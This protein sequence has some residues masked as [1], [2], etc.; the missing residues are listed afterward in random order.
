MKRNTELSYL[1]PVLLVISLGFLLLSA[2]HADRSLT[3]SLITKDGPL[4]ISAYSL[5]VFPNSLYPAFFVLS[6]ILLHVYMRVRLPESDPF[7]LPTVAFLA[8]IGL[9]MMLRLSP[10]LAITR[11][12]VIL[13]VIARN[14]DAQIRNN[15]SALLQLGQKQLFFSIAGILALIISINVFNDRVFARISSKKY[16]WV[17]LSV[18]LI[19]ATL[20][21]GTKING[22]RLWLF[23]FQTVEMVK[24]LMV[25]FMASYIYEKG[26][27]ISIAGTTG[28]RSWP[29]YGGPFLVMCFFAL[30][31][32]FI[33]G[34]LGPTIVIFAVFILL[35]HYAG[36]RDF[37]TLLFVLIIFAVGYIS[38]KSGFPHI[39]RERFDML[40]DPFGRSESISRV[41]WSISSGGL[42]G[43]GIGYGQPYRI[44]EV[45]SDYNF[46][47]ICEEMGLMGAISI[48][49]AY[50]VFI[51]RCFKIASKTENIYKKTLVTAIATMIGVQSFIII[52]GNLN[53]IPMTGIT[54]PFVSYGGS[55]MMMTFLMTGIVLKISG[56]KIE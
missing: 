22:K 37:I 42:W 34:D 7:I 43:S 4:D 21:F 5:A 19:I 9:I 25:L 36:N 33:Q 35:F 6:F 49:L 41:L 51:W 8:G 30:T 23:G 52:S 16:F 38:Y 14:P 13:S 39:V 32:L 29:L 40:I 28:L 26:K 3:D 27:G 55:S 17:L 12:E 2:G 10:D 45:Q 56:E 54:L 46:A 15:V 20:L 1:L 44:P 18:V 50:A 48:L 11:N 31:P 24:F 53:S 47:A